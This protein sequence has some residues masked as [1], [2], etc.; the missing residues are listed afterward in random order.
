MGKEFTLIT[1]AVLKSELPIT[2]RAQETVDLGRKGVVNILNRK[3]ARLLVASG[4]C[5]IHD[6]EAALEYAKRLKALQS[7]VPETM[8]LVMRVYFEKS[9]TTIGWKGFINDPDRDGSFNMNKGLREARKLL[10]KINEMG[11]PVVTELLDPTTYKYIGDLLSWAI[12]GARTIESQTHREMASVLSM[13]VSFKNST[14]GEVGPAIKAM[15]AASS[16]QFFK[17]IDDDGLACGVKASGN[18]NVSIVLRGG[19]TSNYDPVTIGRVSKELSRKGMNPEVVVDCSHDNSGQKFRVQVSVLDNVIGQIV[20]PDQTSP[21]IGV[22][23]ESNLEEGDQEMY[24]N[25]KYGVS[26]TDECIS[27]ETTEAALLRANSRILASK[28][29]VAA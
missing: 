20:D 12:I 21:V 26:I 14:T 23:L 7:R 15:I 5:S 29:A 24:G 19:R 11:V 4:P 10:R 17:G 13:P 27:W 28:Q 18:K 2:K 1:P 6:T 3:D 9:R 16:V 22:M 8:L 25:L